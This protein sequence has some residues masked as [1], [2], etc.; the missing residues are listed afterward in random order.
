MSKSIKV[1]DKVFVSNPTSDYFGKGTFEVIDIDSGGIVT[2]DTKSGPKRY[3]LSSITPVKPLPPD[4][5]PSVKPKTEPIKRA[6]DN[7]KNEL[8]D[9]FKKRNHSDVSN[10][11]PKCG[12]SAVA[13]SFSIVCSTLGCPNY[14]P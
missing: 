4:Y 6:V 7:E 14:S 11:C 2:I 3:R 9:F 10:R 5:K 1:G 8:L 13:L 12:N